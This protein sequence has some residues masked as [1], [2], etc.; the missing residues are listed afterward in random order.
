MVVRNPQRYESLL[1]LHK[2]F[3]RYVINNN[4]VAIS[5]VTGRAL[6][7]YRSGSHVKGNF[8][9]KA[10]VPRYNGCELKPGL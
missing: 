6:H 1:N 2:I 7:S 4:E 10:R 3:I 9:I 5:L 8:D